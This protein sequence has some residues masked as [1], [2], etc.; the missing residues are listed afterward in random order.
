[1]V[2]THVEGCSV[3]MHRQAHLHTDKLKDEQTEDRQTDRQADRQ[4][5]RQTGD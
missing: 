2:Y 5:G 4:A 1:M 3:T